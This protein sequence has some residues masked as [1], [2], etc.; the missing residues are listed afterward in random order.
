MRA[1]F[2]V[3]FPI[4]ALAQ[5]HPTV[6]EIVGKMVESDK[7]RAAS[8]P[9]YTGLRRY[10]LE[11]ERFNKH[12][13]MTVRV[14]CAPGGAKSFQILSES[15]PKPVRSLVL[16]K[17]LDAEADASRSGQRE[18]TLFRPENYGFRLEGSEDVNGRPAFVLA[19]EPK[20]R[21]RYL[22]RGRIWVDAADFAVVK[23]EGSPAKNPS[24]WVSQVSYVH[25]YGKT[26]GFWLPRS[27]RSRSE[28]RIFGP[29]VTAI[30]YT[31]YQM[32]KPPQGLNQ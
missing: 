12:A 26:E 30:E 8:M 24:V 5:S 19:I 20:T 25:Q 17:M 15:G 31:S 16:H 4:L 7:L 32:E 13:E 2:L 14:T 18:Q 29:T 9:G 1:R 11:N 28:A 22:T 23:L 27:N 6:D 3:A 10:T 21:N